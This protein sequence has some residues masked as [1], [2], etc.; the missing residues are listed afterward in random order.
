MNP[1]HDLL[2]KLENIGVPVKVS[3]NQL[4]VND[5]DGKVDSSL[6]S[7]LREHKDNL[8]RHIVITEVS[9]P[10]SSSCSPLGNQ[11]FSNRYLTLIRAYRNGVIDTA[12]RDKGLYFL[13]EHWRVTCQYCQ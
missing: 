12:T 2:S 13:L 5:P 9:S 3:G 1:V 4:L 8:I 11:E 7:Q 6:R 10:G